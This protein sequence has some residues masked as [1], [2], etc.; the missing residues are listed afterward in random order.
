M[1]VGEDAGQ[2]QICGALRVTA[3]AYLLMDGGYGT[4]EERWDAL[5]KIH[6]RVRLRAIETGFAEVQAFIPPAIARKFRGRLKDLKWR[7]DKW[8]KFQFNLPD[9]G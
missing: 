9:G 5:K 4:P 6:E 8:E 1:E 3:E 2:V 7:T